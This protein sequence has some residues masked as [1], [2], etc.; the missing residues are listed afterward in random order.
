M[1]KKWVKNTSNQLPNIVQQT[2]IFL[3]S[4]APSN[5]S[6]LQLKQLIACNLSLCVL[7][8]LKV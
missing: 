2:N 8:P 1:E 7:S 3:K 5:D 6:I 4:E